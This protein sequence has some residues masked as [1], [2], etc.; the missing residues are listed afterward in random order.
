MRPT[1]SQLQL[2]LLHLTHPCLW[3]KVPW[4]F[5]T[6]NCSSRAKQ[7]A[8]QAGQPQHRAAGAVQLRREAARHLHTAGPRHIIR[9]ATARP[10]C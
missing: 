9:P 4:A 3:M 6:H 7:A 10:G 2:C 1:Q 5:T 8:P